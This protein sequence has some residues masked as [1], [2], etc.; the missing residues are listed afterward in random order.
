[1]RKDPPGL[2]RAIHVEILINN[3]SRNILSIAVVM[4]S[5][6]PCNKPD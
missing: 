3:K 4:V 5:G 6:T 2:A 1:L